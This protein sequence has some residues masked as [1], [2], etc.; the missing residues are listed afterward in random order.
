MSVLEG[1][2][3]KECSLLLD[4]TERTVMKTRMR[5]LRKLPLLR[6][7]HGSPIF[8]LHHGDRPN[9]QSVASAH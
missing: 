9:T 7:G 5:A 4:C 6:A 1:Y 2:S 3:T 8:D